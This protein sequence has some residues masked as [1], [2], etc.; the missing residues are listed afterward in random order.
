MDFGNHDQRRGES[1]MSRMTTEINRG[2]TQDFDV[3]ESHSRHQ[4]RRRYLGKVG[5]NTYVR[6]GV[7]HRV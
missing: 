3:A 7:N 2:A 6:E 4:T 5:T 1:R